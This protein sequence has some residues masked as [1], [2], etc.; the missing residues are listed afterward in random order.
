MTEPVITFEKC[1]SPESAREIAKLGQLE[2][3]YIIELATGPN[4]NLVNHWRA[5][6]GVNCANEYKSATSR[7]MA[8]RALVMRMAELF[9]CAG[10]AFALI[11]SQTRSQAGTMGI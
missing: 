11:A 10:P 3:G 6:F 5:Q 4:R 7:Q 9:E 8:K 2:I 1:N